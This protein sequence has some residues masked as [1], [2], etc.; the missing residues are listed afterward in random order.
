MSDIISES[1]STELLSLVLG[2]ECDDPAETEFKN[3]ADWPREG[4]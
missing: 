2:G 1:T 3:P 4:D